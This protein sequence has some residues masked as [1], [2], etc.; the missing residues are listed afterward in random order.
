MARRAPILSR[1]HPAT[2]AWFEESFERPTDA[3]AR[4]WAPIL[5]GR[6][7]LLLAPTGSGK[8]LAAF[9]VA[10]DRATF[11]AEPPPK[12][13]C[14]VLYV[15]PLKALA[16]DVERNLRAPLAGIARTAER[17]GHT[18][19]ALS[20]GVRSGD[21]PASERARLARTPPDVL[22]TT[23]ESL[24]LVLT[25]EARELL[26]SVDTVI[27]DEIHAVASTKRG[28]HLFVS[29]ERLERLRAPSRPPLQRIGLSATQRPLD[30]IARLLGGGTLD[31]DGRWSPRDVAVV[32]ASA[33]KALEI[34]C[35]GH[36]GA[37][38]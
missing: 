13:R 38:R 32:D 10:I 14:R 27:I 18:P 3:Q 37:T 35:P 24:F 1:F 30:E 15:S 19:R 12:E 20:V 33:K 22:I 9:L 26:R 21:T 29:L 31:G 28:S 34:I 2:R 5:D 4:G 36:A 11:G 25:S 8:T 6:S 16:I 17:L 23:P 7:T